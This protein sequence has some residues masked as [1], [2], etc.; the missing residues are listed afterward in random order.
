MIADGAQFANFRGFGKLPTESACSGIKSQAFVHVALVLIVYAQLADVDLVISN[1]QGAGATHDH[2]FG[3]L[4]V[5]ELFPIRRVPGI[6]PC[7]RDGGVYVR[8][9]DGVDGVVLD[10]ELLKT[11][12]WLSGAPDG[13]PC[14]GSIRVNRTDIAG[15]RGTGHHISEF[16]IKGDWLV[17]DLIGWQIPRPE[18]SPFS[19]IQGIETVFYAT[20][21]DAMSEGKLLDG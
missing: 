18:K 17:N 14:V 9:G 2:V 7:A 4:V 20:V 15:N 21:D 10:S 3:G 5:P 11:I 12:V 13:G 6:N 1:Q 19:S 8:F 16:P